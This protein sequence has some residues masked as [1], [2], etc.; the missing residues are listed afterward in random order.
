M[1][2]DL[3][4]AANVDVSEEFHTLREPFHLFWRYFAPVLCNFILLFRASNGAFK[5]SAAEIT[6]FGSLPNVLKT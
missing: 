1:P 5:R 4:V 2:R 6:T 3:I